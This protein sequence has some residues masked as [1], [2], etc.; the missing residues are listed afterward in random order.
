VRSAL[1]AVAT[2]GHRLEARGRRLWDWLFPPRDEPP[3]E[4]LE[5]LRAVYPT[6]DL[7]A[8][9]FHRGMPHLIRCLGSQAIV[10]PAL[11]A[12]RRTRVY[13]TP[14]VWDFRG[15]AG[16]GTLVHEGYHALQVQDAGWGIAP[17]RPFVILYFARGAANGFRYQGHPMEEAAFAVA[18]DGASRFESACA[19]GWAAGPS[20]LE[21]AGLP[22]AASGVR[23]WRDLAASVPLAPAPL[24]R[25]VLPFWLLL[26]TLAAFLAWL[27]RLGVE[28]AGGAAAVALLETG[29]FVKSLAKLF[30]LND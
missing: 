8:V 10:I 24:A 28:A 2:V 15:P 12:R 22:V 27:A 17:F 26:W 4:A 7:G 5:V 20:P 25:G 1:A 11:L 3:A 13:F 19:A 6:L 30:D 9:A 29:F 21:R 14:E 18:G 23:F 16:L